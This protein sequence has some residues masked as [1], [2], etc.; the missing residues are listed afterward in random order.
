VLPVAFRRRPPLR[1]AGEP[2]ALFRAIP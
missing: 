2:V 1:T